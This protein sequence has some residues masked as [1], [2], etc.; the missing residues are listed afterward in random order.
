MK[1]NKEVT[2]TLKQNSM[3]DIFLNIFMNGVIEF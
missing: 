2:I 1:D 3:Q